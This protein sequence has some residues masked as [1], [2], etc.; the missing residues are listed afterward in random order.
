MLA[1]HLGDKSGE[2]LSDGLGLLDRYAAVLRERGV[3]L[4]EIVLWGVLS[5]LDL[6]TFRHE[7][8]ER[9]RALSPLSLEI[10]LPLGEASRLPES[11][12]TDEGPIQDP[13]QLGGQLRKEIRVFPS[14]QSV[15]VHREPD[16]SRTPTPPEC[17]GLVLH[18][19]EHVR[20]EDQLRR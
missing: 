13:R 1:T 8:V 4:V 2:F 18:V 3:G 19:R 16:K 11:S 20:A 7:P 12:K 9:I 14:R 17:N 10:A 6:D 15:H 5:H